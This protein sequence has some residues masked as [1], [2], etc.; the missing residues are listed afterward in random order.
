MIFD[1]EPTDHLGPEEQEYKNKLAYLRKFYQIDVRPGDL[2]KYSSNGANYFG[3]VVDIS[4]N[5]ID[6]KTMT[7][8][9][10]GKIQWS[11]D[12]PD[13]KSWYEFNSKN[14]FVMNR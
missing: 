9:V 13:D 8:R 11:L 10:S 1:K 14:W 6:S 3:L 4:K 5:Y 7:E 12:K 2:I